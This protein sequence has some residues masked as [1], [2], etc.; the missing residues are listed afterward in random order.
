MGMILDPYDGNHVVI[1]YRIIP[2][3]SQFSDINGFL[4]LLNPTKLIRVDLELI[5]R[6]IM[7]ANRPTNKNDLSMTSFLSE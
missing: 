5:I 6:S 4:F 2:V 1:R 7:D 3:I